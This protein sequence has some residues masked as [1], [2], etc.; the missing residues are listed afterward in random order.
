M[1]Q[2]LFT[3]QARGTCF[4]REVVAGCTTFMAMSYVLFVN[5]AMLAQ[6]GMDQGAVFVATCLAAALGCLLMGLLANLPVA[7]APGMGLNAFF[8]YVIVLEQ[9]HSWQTALACV[10]FSGCLFLLLSLFKVREWI[11]NSIPLPLKMGI[12]AGIGMFLALI[13]L[14]TANI[15][16]ASPAT[17][18]TLGDLHSPQVVLALLG[19]FIIFALAHRGWHA[20][21]LISIVLVTA[22]AWWLGDT[23]FSAVVAMPPSLMPTFMQLDFAAALQLSMLPVILSLLFLDLFDTSG[24]L[25]AVSH[26]AGLMQQDGRLPDL[27]KALIAD[28]SATIA[29][30][31]LG[32]STTTSYVESTSGVAAGGRT[33]LTAVIT[34]LLFLAALWFSPLAAMVPAY[35]TAGAL[36]Y[37]ATLMLSS[38]QH[39]QW[40]DVLQAVPVSV[41][42]IM[43]PLTFSISDGIGMGFISYAVLCL[44]TGKL[45]RTTLSVWILALVFLAK[46]IWA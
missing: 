41:V 39:V 7:L 6:T 30:A 12:A 13:A 26:K 42:L 22:A 18:V 16:V 35:A 38:L 5:P 34:G 19:F 46:F 11:I 44:L 25:V 36:L 27:S 14:K 10:F 4:K 43:M 40:D 33:G 1:L 31:M 28:S 17:L 9:G 29:G 23:Q 32:T 15:I 24:T 3:L 37:V 2:R 20:A 8:T 45:S 21:V